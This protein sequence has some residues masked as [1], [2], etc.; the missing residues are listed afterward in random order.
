[1]KK[2]HVEEKLTDLVQAFHERNEL[3]V[4]EIQNLISCNR[5]SVYNYIDRLAERGF[6]I[7]RKTKNRAVYF[8]LIQGNAP[9]ANNHYIRLSPKILRKYSIIQ[10]L[11]LAPY[12]PKTLASRFLIFPSGQKPEFDAKKVPIDIAYTYFNT[13]V[14]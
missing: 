12:T 4:K 6:C 8:S 1:M 14:K 2:K 10:Q 11:H 3:S 13:L 5:Q 9:S 7:Q